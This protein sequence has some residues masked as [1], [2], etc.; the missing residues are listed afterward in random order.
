MLLLLLPSPL[1]ARG[2]PSPRTPSASP[3]SQW[4]A[5]SPLAPRS[6]RSSA[7]NRPTSSVMS[8]GYASS[9]RGEDGHYGRRERPRSASRRA[10]SRDAATPLSAAAARAAPPLGSGVGP[11]ASL[12][13]SA[14]A[15]RPDAPREE[16]WQCPRHT[17]RALGAGRCADSSASL[18]APHSCPRAGQGVRHSEPERLKQLGARAHGP[19]HW[20]IRRNYCY[21]TQ[22]VLSLEPLKDSCLAV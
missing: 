10:R 12:L 11:T 20:R 5:P 21:S 16:P 22:Y 18:C 17:C 6:T 9:M 2:H 3:I 13:P 8:A 19:R 14:P 15:G 1:A 7:P 4:R